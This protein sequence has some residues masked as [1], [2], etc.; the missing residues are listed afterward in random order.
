MRVRHNKNA[1]EI[2]RNNQSQLFIDNAEMQHGKWRWYFNNNKPLHL[3]IGCGKGQFIIN[4]ALKYPDINF[5]A[6]ERD[7]TILTKA[8][9]KAENIK[10][11]GYQINNLKFI[12]GDASKIEF[13][14]DD[15]ELDLIF[16]NFSDPWPKKRQTKRRLTYDSFLSQYFKILKPAS[17]IVLKTD[18]L[19]FFNYSLSQFENNTKWF[20]LVYSTFDLYNELNLEINQ[21][22]ISTEYEDKFHQAG[23]KINKLVAI[24]NKKY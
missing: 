8:L 2:L 17:K 9:K 1:V 7:A 16:L 20:N 14:F 5:L 24:S 13:I 19:D 12:L 18:N 10:A 21:D 11:M 15:N 3:E 23:T 6:L 22:N 4:A